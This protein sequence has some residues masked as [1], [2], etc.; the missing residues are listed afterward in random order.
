M[1]KIF[2]ELLNIVDKKA[3]S[4]KSHLFHAQ[5]PYFKSTVSRYPLQIPACHVRIKSP[6]N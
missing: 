2:E 1:M 3:K 6:S 4:Q 5:V